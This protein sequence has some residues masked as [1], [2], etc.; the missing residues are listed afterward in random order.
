MACVSCASNNGAEFP[1]EIVLHFP[2]SGLEGLNKNG[3]FLY[4]KV[5]VCLDCGFSRFT[6]AGTEVADL[7]KGIG[8]RKPANQRPDPGAEQGCLGIS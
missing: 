2:F 7:A 1:S 8:R 5:L 6:T 3:V 4:P